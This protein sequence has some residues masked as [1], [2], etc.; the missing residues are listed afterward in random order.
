MRKRKTRED[1][2]PSDGMEQ[3]REGKNT[4]NFAELTR[5]NERTPD[6]LFVVFPMPR[7]ASILCATELLRKLR[8]TPFLSQFLSCTFHI[9]QQQKRHDDSFSFPCWARS[10]VS[11]ILQVETR[12][13]KHNFSI[14]FYESRFSQISPYF[15]NLLK[16]YSAIFVIWYPQ[17][18]SSI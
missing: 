14:S 15:T 2:M 18:I 11:K 12:R 16:K 6:G 3:D 1:K 4:S 10:C 8:W 9:E 7:R 5:V 17:R 13:G